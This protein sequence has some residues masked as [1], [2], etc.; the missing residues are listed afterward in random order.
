MAK[1]RIKWGD[2]EA[3][4]AYWKGFRDELIELYGEKSNKEVSPVPQ[5]EKTQDSDFEKAKTFY[6]KLA[7]GKWE[8]D[9]SRR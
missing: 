4:D 2:K 6:K 7:N 3:M 8:I 9:H 1:V 5:E